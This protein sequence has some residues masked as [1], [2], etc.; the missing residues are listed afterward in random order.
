MADVIKKV[1]LGNI[2]A[3]AF[4]VL[5]IPRHIRG[6]DKYGVILNHGAASGAAG[7]GSMWDQ[8]GW[9]SQQKLAAVLA[10]DGIPVIT[11]YAGG[12]SWANDAVSE[13]S[14]NGYVNKM[15]AY[16]AA[17]TGCAADKAIVGGTSM[18]AGITARWAS[19][20]QLKAAAVFGF[21]PALS[22][23]HLYTD[24]PNFLV[25]SNASATY[26]IALAWGLTQRFVSDAVIN[27]TTTLTSATANFQPA[28]V[29]RQIV[30]GYDQT[31]IQVNTKIASRESTTSVTLDKV[32]GSGSG[33]RIVIA[34]PLP[35]SGTAGA[36]LIGVHAPRLTDIPNRWYYASDDAFV[37]QADVLAFAAAADGEIFD[38]GNL[39]HTNAALAAGENLNGGEDWSDLVDWIKE[40][41]AA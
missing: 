2:Q 3:A 22:I 13:N 14:V 38:L 40:A 34:D 12:N 35:M 17:Q 19:L 36:D 27:G 26:Q 16:M 10:R 15:L 41:G 32:A 33:Q 31:G 25:A 1:R 24:N 20:N 37:Y 9:M 5:W 11:A 28:D 6:A 39:G 18:G 7:T 21:I 4:D 8:I 23:E 29:G 30:R